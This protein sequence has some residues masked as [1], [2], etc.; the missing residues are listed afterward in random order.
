MLDQVIQFADSVNAGSVTIRVDKGA[1]TVILS[2][3]KAPGVVF[4]LPALRT[5]KGGMINDATAA[6]ALNKQLANTRTGKVS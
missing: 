2:A 1:D 3:D 5:S 4:A 6:K